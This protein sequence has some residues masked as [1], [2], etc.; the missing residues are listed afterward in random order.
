MARQS[1]DLSTIYVGR[2][3]LSSE[4]RVVNLALFVPLDT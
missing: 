4:E 3:I 1:S 2:Y